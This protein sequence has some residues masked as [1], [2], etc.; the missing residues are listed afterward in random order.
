MPD[1]S[2][3]GTFVNKN[4]DHL[5]AL[6]ED[7]WRNPKTAAKMAEA[8]ALAAT[9]VN[10]SSWIMFKIP[11]NHE[12]N[13][14]KFLE[15]QFKDNDAGYFVIRAKSG[16]NDN[17]NDIDS[18]FFIYGLDIEVISCKYTRYSSD[19]P[20]VIDKDKLYGMIKQLF[21]VSLYPAS[22]HR[23]SR[24][25]T[26][27]KTRHQ[28][29]LN[30]AKRLVR[31][32]ENTKTSAESLQFLGELMVHDKPFMINTKKPAKLSILQETGLLN[33]DQLSKVAEFI[34]TEWK[35][36]DKYKGTPKMGGDYDRSTGEFDVDDRE[37]YTIAL[38]KE[39]NTEVMKNWQPLPHPV[40]PPPA[41]DDNAGG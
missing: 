34:N 24:W 2:L 6:L 14:T 19:P 20:E 27:R 40:I 31:Y 21:N 16:D 30:R 9:D 11:Y 35:N 39:G 7:R 15:R 3:T 18:W 10:C 13:F 32:A 38:Q 1:Q 12:V 22:D 8:F 4:R 26:S 23:L 5:Y 37:S 28:L 41:K 17:D 25:S 33:D 36:V 29:V